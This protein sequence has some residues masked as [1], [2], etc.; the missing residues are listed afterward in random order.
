MTHDCWVWLIV[1]ALVAGCAGLY[2]G[3]WFGYYADEI[4][5]HGDD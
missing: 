5:H 4:Q 3:S 2:L 1:T